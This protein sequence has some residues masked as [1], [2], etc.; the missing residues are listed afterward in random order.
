[1]ILLSSQSLVLGQEPESKPASK[2]AL[3]KTKKPEEKSDKG[4]V[5]VRDQVSTDLTKTEGL[6]EF[7]KSFNKSATELLDGK[8][9][10]AAFPKMEVRYWDKE[11]RVKTW[12]ALK[13]AGAVKLKLLGVELII[14]I[15][16]GN[17]AGVRLKM[18]LIF[19]NDKIFLVPNAFYPSDDKFKPRAMLPADLK[20]DFTF[21]GSLARTL[22]SKAKEA[23]RSKNFPFISEDDFAAL[24]DMAKKG[25]T[26]EEWNKGLKRGLAKQ[27]KIFVKLKGGDPS[28]IHVE[29]DDAVL[30]VEDKEGKHLGVLQADFDLHKKGASVEFQTFMGRD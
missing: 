25:M 23:K 9:P 4:K 16:E 12:E 10:E 19:H 21:V 7:L 24:G 2:P 20:K 14:E 28:T 13:K 26:Q 22:M 5:S 8:K 3:D 11:R 1:M 18:T 15:P 30:R 29:I 17:G 27:P 6:K